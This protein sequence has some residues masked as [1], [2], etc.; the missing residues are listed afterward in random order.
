MPDD[1]SDA[2]NRNVTIDAIV[3]SAA[4]ARKH[5]GKLE[6]RLQGE[7]DDIDFVA[8]AENRP[9]TEAEREQ[10]RQLRASQTEVR[11]AFVQLAFVTLQRLDNSLE[12]LS[13]NK[14]MQAIQKNLADDLGTLKNIERIADTVA[15]VSDSVAQVVASCRTDCRKSS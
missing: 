12:I 11:D 1:R 10:R 8:F 6:H 15:K 4:E 14:R 5:L 2:V 13:L 9:L 3:A 7:I